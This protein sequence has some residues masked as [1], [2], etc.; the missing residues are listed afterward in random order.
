MEEPAGP[1]GGR[2]ECSLVLGVVSEQEPSAWGVGGGA[3]DGAVGVLLIREKAWEHL[4]LL[5]PALQ[6]HK[7]V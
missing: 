1:P 6:G 4:P 5:P 7:H 3:Q 2:Q